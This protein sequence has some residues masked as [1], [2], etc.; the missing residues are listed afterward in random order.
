MYFPRTLWT[1]SFTVICVIQAALVLAF[2]GYV[3]GKFQVALSNGGTSSV[4]ARSVP[5]YLVLFIFGLLY[6]IV[7]VWDALR[8]KNTIQIIGICIYNAGLLVY[9]AVQVDQIKRSIT[10]L[11]NPGPGMPR[12]LENNENIWQDI[13]PFLTVVPCILALGSVLLSAVAWKLYGEFSWSI[14]K[15]ISADLRMKR[16]YLTYQIYI[17]LLKFDFFFFLGFTVQFLV[18]V[19][20]NVE[21]RETQ[22]TIA[23]IPITI[24]ILLTAAWATRTE[25]KIATIATIL[26]YFAAL[27][28]FI[29]KLVRIFQPLE[30]AKFDYKP[31]RRPLATFAVIA[32]VLIVFTIANACVCFAN[33]NKGLK[34]HIN[35]PKHDE[36]ESKLDMDDMSPPSHQHGPVPSRMVID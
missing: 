25:N 3:F 5:T 12:L 28:Y 33:F 35:K 20:F 10:A 11:L 15:H 17:A 14:Y 6:Q 16:R 4:G 2:E 8:L 23:A 27:A 1:I 22:L 34:K 13:K 21:D 18:I 29:F 26:L 30:D 7:L 19:V 32:L 24:I 36:E 31:G 9:A